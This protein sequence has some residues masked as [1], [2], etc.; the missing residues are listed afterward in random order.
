MH[1]TVLGG[2]TEKMKYI[3]CGLH[4]QGVCHLTGGINRKQV[5]NSRVSENPQLCSEDWICSGESQKEEK[6]GCESEGVRKGF[7]KKW[8]LS[9]GLSVG[10]VGSVQS[11]SCV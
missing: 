7:L 1:S 6:N 4:P 8:Y 2:L 3:Q 9:W 5:T 10:G 11:L